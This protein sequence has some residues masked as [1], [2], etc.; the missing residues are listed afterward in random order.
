MIWF[1]DWRIAVLYVIS[2]IIIL[3]FTLRRL[4]QLIWLD[5]PINQYM[6]DT[7]SRTS[8]IITNIK[9]VKAFANEAKELKRQKR[10][11]NRELMVREYRIHKGYVK[12]NTWQKTVIQFCMFTVLGWTLVE[13]IKGKISLG[14]FIMTLTISSMAYAELEPFTVLAEIFARRYPSMMSF[15]KFLKLPTGVD[16]LRLLEEESTS[17]DRYQF[18][19]K[20]EFSHIYFGYEPERPVL[21]DVNLLIEPCQTLALV[22][23]S[24]SGKSTLLKLLLR[25]FEP[26]QGKILIDGQ[27]IC[28]LDVGSYRRRLAIVH[29]E[30]KLMFLTELCSTTSHMA[31]PMLVLIR[32]KKAVESPDW[33][34]FCRIYLKAITQ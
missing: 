30:V 29:Q 25:Y 33:M 18:T 9:T 28:S 12:L 23:Y 21:Q 22:G 3:R 8:E 5:N 15:H 14:H 16:A 26:Q 20:I 34:K 7:E 19:G 31:I 11:F 13:T 27:D 4:Q 32:L 6:E 1:V 17:S 10:R 24:G 2:F